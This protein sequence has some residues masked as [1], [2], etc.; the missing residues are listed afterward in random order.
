LCTHMYRQA[1]P[2]PKTASQ[3]HARLRIPKWDCGQ[4]QRKPRL[5]PLCGFHFG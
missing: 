1:A 5:T 3:P 4:L 2:D